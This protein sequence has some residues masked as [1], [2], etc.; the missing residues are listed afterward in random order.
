MPKQERMKWVLPTVVHPPTSVCFEIQVPNERHYIGAFLGAIYLLSKPYAWGDD[1][2]HTA[3][4][5]GAVWRQ[6][7]DNL[8]RNNCNVCP[9]DNSFILEDND[10]ELRQ[11]G[12]LLQAKCFDGSWVTIYD[13]TNCITSGSVN[14]TPG[15]QL[16]PGTC[17]KYPFALQANNQAVLPVHV[18][19][20]DTIQIE[21]PSGAWSGDN[22]TQWNCID[23]SIFILGGC[24]GSAG[25]DGGDPLP[26]APHM[27]LIALI[28]GSYYQIQ[29]G[30][31]PVPSGVTPDSQV[32]FLANDS[33]R[34]DNLGSISFTAEVCAAADD[35]FSI[36]YGVG[37]GPATARYG[38]NFTVA[39]AAT[40]GVQ[41]FDMTFS[42]CVKLTILGYTGFVEIGSGGANDWAY[43]DC[44]VVEHD[45][46][47]SNSGSTPLDW[48]PNTETERLTIEG[49]AG[50]P[51]T[52]LCKAERV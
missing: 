26:T 43:W 50:H 48:V 49:A 15:P 22:G 51:F 41:A 9:P 44:A 29:P 19:P 31:F 6:I 16:T 14:P 13:P 32:M 37:T 38:D 52:V 39:S 3:L 45:G 2:A 5:V 40:G 46:P 8:R 36:S 20:G 10:M 1:A 47:L 23:G 34:S 35:L 30:V 11:E 7:F 27:S 28:D 12:C 42:P 21:D 25:T 18:S 4:E 24:V 17:A 33:D